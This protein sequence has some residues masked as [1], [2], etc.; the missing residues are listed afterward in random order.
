MFEIFDVFMKQ[1]PI[2]VAARNRQEA[3]D[4]VNQELDKAN[5]PGKPKKWYVIEAGFVKDL[6][7]GMALW[8]VIPQIVK[9]GRVIASGE[10]EG[11]K[12]ACNVFKLGPEDLVVRQ[13]TRQI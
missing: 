1:E 6:G 13:K 9:I 4:K 3:V 7:K 12:I 8:N 11:L 2:Q 5:E 10:E